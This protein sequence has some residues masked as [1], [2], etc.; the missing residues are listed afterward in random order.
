[1]D[2]VEEVT[3]P[4]SSC[5]ESLPLDLLAKIGS[6]GQPSS[7]FHPDSLPMEYPSPAKNSMTLSVTSREE[8]FS[9]SEV[10]LFASTWPPKGILKINMTLYF[11]IFGRFK[12][13]DPPSFLT[14]LRIN[15]NFPP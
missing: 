15:L 8:V 13:N 3:E 7:D 5:Q 4:M 9:I 2:T 10:E 1:M 11:Q 6:S 12:I 14:I